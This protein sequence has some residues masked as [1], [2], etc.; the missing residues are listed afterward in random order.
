VTKPTH[1]PGPWFLEKPE[2]DYDAISGVD[3]YDLASVVIRVDGEDSPEGQANAARIVACVNACEGLADPSVVP[4]LVTALECVTDDLEAE[5]E[6]R[7]G[8]VLQ[9]TLDRDLEVVHQA[10]AAIAKAKGEGA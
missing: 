4:E 10:R 9:R 3:W 5:I 7:R 2:G 6:D 8:S 1:T